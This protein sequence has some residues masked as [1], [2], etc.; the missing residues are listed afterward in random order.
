MLE[1][2]NNLNTS[3]VILYVEQLKDETLTHKA[4]HNKKYYAKISNNVEELLELTL[5]WELHKVNIKVK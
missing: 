3:K 4:F 5:A 2:I 1:V